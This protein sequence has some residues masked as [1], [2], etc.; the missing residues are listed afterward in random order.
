MIFF[1]FASF[2]IQ[3]SVRTNPS[4]YESIEDLQMEQHTNLIMADRLT[5]GAVKLTKRAEYEQIDEQLQF[6]AT[7][8]S[9]IT[10]KEYFKSAR[11]LFHFLF[12]YAIFDV[13]KCCLTKLQ[14]QVSKA[15][16][17][18]GSS[19]KVSNVGG[20]TVYV[21]TDIQRRRKCERELRKIFV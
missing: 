13:I 6:L 18:G 16:L 8:L 21:P 10:R 1:L 3:N 11:T 19:V 14:T 2:S 4:I 15:H 12:H 9:T 20:S 17:L 7:S 5:A